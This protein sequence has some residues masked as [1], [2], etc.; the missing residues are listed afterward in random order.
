VQRGQGRVAAAAPE[1][2]LELLQG[3][4]RVLGRAR[5][6]RAHGR[7]RVAERG[8]VPLE[9]G[10]RRGA[11]GAQVAELQEEEQVLVLADRV[12]LALEGRRDAGGVR[13]AAARGSELGPGPEALVEPR[14]APLELAQ[15]DRAGRAPAGGEQR[16]G[17]GLHG[18]RQAV[19]AELARGGEAV[20]GRREAREQRGERGRGP[21]ARRA[22]AR[23]RRARRRQRGEPRR[24]VEAVPA[25]QEVVAGQVVDGD[26]HDGAPAVAGL[27]LELEHQVR[28]QRQVAEEAGAAGAG[29]P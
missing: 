8:E 29:E 16:L 9:P 7:L 6:G 15:R 3:S 23:R 20:L 27:G 22:V 11:L 12:E 13:R 26:Q 24:R 21:G 10:R 1:Q 25:G 18:G 17:Q 4:R 5:E 14:E 19:G 28:D 2:A